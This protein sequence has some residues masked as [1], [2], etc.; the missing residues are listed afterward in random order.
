MLTSIQRSALVMYSAQ[1]MFDLVNDVTAYPAFMEGCDGAKILE[2]DDGFMIARLDLRKKGIHTSFVT[3]NTLTPP[4]RIAL[5]LHSGPF[6]QLRGA[7]DFKAL[8]EQACKVSFFL[9]FESH[10]QLVGVAA[11]S[12]FTSVTNS[13]VQAISDRANMVYGRTRG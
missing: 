13:L 7:W 4:H 10:S 2:E 8:S 3:R 9:E 1:D 12:L 11:S 6:K 5:E